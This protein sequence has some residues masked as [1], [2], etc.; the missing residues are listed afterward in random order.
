[1][2]EVFDFPQYSEEWWDARKGLVTASS[3]KVLTM[4]GRGGGESETRK[5]LVID[6]AAEIVSGRV[7]PSFSSHDMERG[8]EEEEENRNRYGYDNDVE[9]EIVG[10]I[11]NGRKGGSPDALI[12]SDG[13]LE[14]KSHK[15]TI[16]IPMMQADMF[17]AEHVPQCQFLMWVCEREWCDLSAYSRGLPRFQKRI[18]RDEAYIKTLSDELNRFYEEVDEMV[19]WLKNYGVAA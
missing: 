6:T 5:K 19:T 10:F 9:P 18:H 2:I 15:P 3:A 13:I 11:R 16:L 14:C 7:A 8:H 1:M 12:G 17:P 4:K